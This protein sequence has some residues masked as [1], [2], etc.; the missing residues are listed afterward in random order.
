MPETVAIHPTAPLAERVLAPGDPGRALLLSQS[1]LTEPKMFNHNRGLW[2]Y[3][4]A[5]GR[6]PAADHPEH[7]H[8]RAERGDRD[9]GAAPA[10]A[11]AGGAGRDAAPRSSL[12]SISA[13]W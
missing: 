8:G 4:G 12:T 7:R 10:W 9:R 1:L 2:G 3:T 5:G 11:P 6:R 13:S